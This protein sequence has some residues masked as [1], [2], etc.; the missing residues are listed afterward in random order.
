MLVRSV[1]LRIITIMSSSPGDTP[2]G[3]RQVGSSGISMLTIDD[4]WGTL[5]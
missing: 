4:S 5:H 3:K 1:C 2:I